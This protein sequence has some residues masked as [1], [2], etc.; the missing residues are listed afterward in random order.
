MHGRF[1]FDGRNCMVHEELI[2]AGFK[3]RGIGRSPSN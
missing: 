3:Y 1:V 2:E